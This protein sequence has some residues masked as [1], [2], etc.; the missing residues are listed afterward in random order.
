[1]AERKYIRI[2]LTKDDVAMLEE[3]KYTVEEMTGVALSDSNF[4][5]SVIRQSLKDRSR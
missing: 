4:V 1:M 2:A 5:L 3:V